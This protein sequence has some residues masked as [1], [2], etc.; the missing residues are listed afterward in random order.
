MKNRY[1]VY[2][3]TSVVSALFDKRNPE[4]M[5]LTR[6][7][8]DNSH[9]FEII[10]SEL[11]V[12]EI[13]ATPDSILRNKMRAQINSFK[14]VDL[15]SGVNKLTDEIIRHGA[16]PLNF[17]E[18]AFHI[19]IAILSKADFLACWNFKHIVRRKTRDIIRMITTLN[20][21]KNIEI[22]TPAELL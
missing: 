8:F 18:D 3:D 19:S 22:I 6:N 15:P 20:D 1:K 7:F 21:L 2:L 13:E 12:A 11:T 9:L 14:I 17:N 5:N 16:V 10:I 4:R